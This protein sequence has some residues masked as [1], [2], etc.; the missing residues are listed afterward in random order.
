M[1]TLKKFLSI[2]GL[3][4]GASIAAH[5]GTVTYIY[6][7]NQGTPL[8]EADAQGNVTATFDYRP[9]G[10]QA[11]GTPPKGPGYTGHV[12]DPDTGLVYMQSRYYDP[13]VG[14]FLSVDSVRPAP[15]RTDYTNRYG[16]VGDNPMSRVDPTG[17]YVCNGKKDECAVISKAL[18]LVSN[19]ANKLSDGS[20]GK[21][22]LADIV[23]FYGAEGKANGVT[24]KFGTADG[25]NGKTETTGRRSDVGGRQTDITF[26]LASMSTTGSHGGTTQTAES[27]ATVAHEGQHGIDG[28]NFGRPANK[29]E[30]LITEF[31]AYTT[32]SYV[33]EGLGLTSPYGVWEHGWKDN[34]ESN[35]L[36]LDMAAG[37]ALNDVY[38]EKN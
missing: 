11:L 14:R 10:A 7:D 6:T 30:L 24:V 36:R 21:Q 31:N 33:N 18:T 23:S 29:T 8:A 38:G 37:D 13:V 16:Y 12:N 15:G 9:Y 20:K 27:A 19:A 17:D 34:Q 32:Q 35:F 1:N 28:V 22:A 3:W 25:N 5:A 26:N 4:L 2:V